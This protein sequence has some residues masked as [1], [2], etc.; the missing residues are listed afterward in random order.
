MSGLLWKSFLLDYKKFLILSTDCENFLHVL[1]LDLLMFF[2]FWLMRSSEQAKI[3]K[4][5]SRFYYPIKSDVRYFF[6]L[7][8]YD[9]TFF[10][11]L[12][13][14][15]YGVCVINWNKKKT[16]THG[17]SK[18]NYSDNFDMPCFAKDVPIACFARW[19]KMFIFKCCWFEF[20]WSLDEIYL[21]ANGTQKWFCAATA[22]LK[23]LLICKNYGASCL[24]S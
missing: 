14:A 21:E 19:A 20:W 9:L 8:S 7:C 4:I 23:S 18:F 3:W 13:R 12:Y 2:F 16:F 11:S 22:E 15:A 6:N 17:S 24:T 10:L 1:R 5:P